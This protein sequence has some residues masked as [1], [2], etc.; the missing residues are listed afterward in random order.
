MGNINWSAHAQ[1]DDT[2]ES[3]LPSIA[4]QS[5]QHQHPLEALMLAVAHEAALLQETVKVHAETEH[6]FDFV[7]LQSRCR[8]VGIEQECC[9]IRRI[10]YD[11]VE[12]HQ[13]TSIAN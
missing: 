4:D 2:F 7:S 3:A 1:R 10:G 8:L 11:R 9:W 13:F 6:A 5:I 12:V